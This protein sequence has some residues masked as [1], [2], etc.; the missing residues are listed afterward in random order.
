MTK[1]TNNI[2]KSDMS[3]FD[4]IPMTMERIMVAMTG[5][6]LVIFEADCKQVAFPLNNIESTMLV[7]VQSGCIRKEHIRTIYD[8]YLDTLEEM[9]VK[10][11]ENVIESQLGDI[12]Y[13]RLHFVDRKNRKF[14]TQCSAGDVIV[15]SSITQNPVKIIRKTLDAMD[16]FEMEIGNM[17]DDNFDFD[18]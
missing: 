13:G 14:Y 4:L 8:L 16:P 3:E 10:L 6:T 5:E 7:F 9:G 2:I 11:I 1:K 18:E 17:G 15:F 12:Y